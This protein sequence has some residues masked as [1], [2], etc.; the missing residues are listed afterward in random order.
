MSDEGIQPDEPG[1]RPTGVRAGKGA[2][3]RGITSASPG[4]RS[5]VPRAR[6]LNVLVRRC[7]LAATALG[8]TVAIAACV[9]L[10]ARPRQSVAILPGT[11]KVV[12]LAFSPD[13][14]TLAGGYKG[15]EAVGGRWNGEVKLW[16]VATSTERL[17]IPLPQWAN[18]VAF[19][20]TARPWPSPAGAT[21]RK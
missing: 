2:P 9:V 13:G 3:E 17:S 12:S 1:R 11:G 4:H 5:D 10:F 19:S 18:C 15:T 20:P 8:M 6:K 21:T 16:D 7:L 14:A